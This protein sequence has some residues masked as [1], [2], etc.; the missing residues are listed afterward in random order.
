MKLYRI[1]SRNTQFWVNFEQKRSDLIVDSM[2]K[3][4]IVGSDDDDDKKN[5]IFPIDT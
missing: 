3:R 4:R 5:E 1:N 2:N